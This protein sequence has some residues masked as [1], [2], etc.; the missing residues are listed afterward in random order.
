MA[1]SAWAFPIDVVWCF[2]ESVPVPDG[3]SVPEDFSCD[4]AFVVAVWV[5]YVGTD[6]ATTIGD[7]LVI[8]SVTV[9]VV[10]TDIVVGAS[11]GLD[12]VWSGFDV[13]C[14]WAWV[15]RAHVCASFE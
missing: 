1:V 6:A 7:H 9:L 4:D 11:I 12:S 13:S 15:V 10:G 3:S 8:V 5:C 14:E 2:D